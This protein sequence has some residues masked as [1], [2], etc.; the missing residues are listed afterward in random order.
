MPNTAH[1]SVWHT[2]DGFLAHTIKSEACYFVSSCCLKYLG[3]MSR[4]T[5]FYVI[6][7]EVN[8][9]PIIIM[10]IKVLKSYKKKAQICMKS[11]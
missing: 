11:W 9:L 5:F 10:T 2:T 3:Q 8:L 7:L 1:I 4:P 6:L